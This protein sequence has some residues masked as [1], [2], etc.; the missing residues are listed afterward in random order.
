MLVDI[1]IS[2]IVDPGSYSEGSSPSKIGAQALGGLGGWAGLTRK[3]NGGRGRYFSL[4]PQLD[5]RGLICWYEFQINQGL[6]M[7]HSSGSLV[8]RLWAESRVEFS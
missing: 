5:L 2:K 8:T 1:H 3:F 6:H 7:I 4:Q